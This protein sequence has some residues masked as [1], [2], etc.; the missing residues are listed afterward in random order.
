MNQNNDLPHPP[1]TPPP[2]APPPIPEWHDAGATP[3]AVPPPSAS[4]GAPPPFSYPSY[5]ATQPGADTWQTKYEKEKKRSLLFAVT[6]AGASVLAVVA[7]VWGVAQSPSATATNASAGLPGSSTGQFPGG[8]TTGQMPG[9]TTGQMPGGGG[10]GGMDPA[11]DLF[12]ADGSINTSA[13]EQFFAM[14]PPGL[15]AATLISQ[16]ES[17]GAIT[18]DQATALREAAADLPT[19]SGTTSG[20]TGTTGTST[21][22]GGNGTSTTP[23]GTSTTSGTTSDTVGNV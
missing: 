11:T 19:A 6:T 16:M 21:T 1:I 23:T 4:Q 9:G 5:P 18:S 3:V 10:P 7:L 22:S 15:D 12:N 8:G 20:G 2:V 14:M 17:G 13:V